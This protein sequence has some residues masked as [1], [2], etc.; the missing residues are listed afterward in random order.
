MVGRA[1]VDFAKEDPY[2]GKALGKV[3]QRGGVFVTILLGG[4]I[5]VILGAVWTL[6]WCPAVLSFLQGTLPLVL[7]M[8]GVMAIYFGVDEIL[9]PA[10][11]M[12]CVHESEQATQNNEFSPPS[13]K[14]PGDG[15]EPL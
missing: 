2:R 9:Y 11:P 12:P 3:L 4:I 13:N 1:F 7:V 6:L 14:V 15:G 10:P 8:G 5:A